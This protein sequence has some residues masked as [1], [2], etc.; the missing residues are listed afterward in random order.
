MMSACLSAGISVAQ[1]QTENDGADTEFQ[2][3]EIVVTATRRE[4]RLVDISQSITALT[5]SELSDLG[6]DSLSSFAGLVPSL[7][8]TERG[9]GRTSITI[10]GVS[11]DPGTSSVSPVGI[12]IDDI[13]I[14]N[15]D[16]NSQADVR[17][18][19]LQRVEVLR[20]PQ[21]TLYGEG[22][23]GGV[24][25]YITNKA[26]PSDFASAVDMSYGSISGGDNSTA[27]DAMVNLPII[28]DKLALRIVGTYRDLGGYIDNPLIGVENFN[29]SEINALR[30]SLLW[31]LTDNATVTLGG[32]LSDIEVAGDNITRGGSRTEFIAPSLNPRQDD[33]DLIH[34]TFEYGFPAF[35]FTSVSGFHT[36]DSA[37]TFVDSDLG[38]QGFVQPAVSAISDVI[39]ESSV[40][41]LGQDNENF[42]QELRLVSN[43]EGPLLWTLGAWY[44]DGDFTNTGSRIVG[45][46]P[47]YG[48]T[49]DLFFL[50]VP[51][52]LGPN[53][54]GGP[55]G[56]AIPGNLMNFPSTSGYENTAIFGEVSYQLTD[57]LNVQLGARYFEE[58]RSTKTPLE[59]GGFF[60]L[61][62]LLNDLQGIPNV[63][64]DE[65][66]T[67]N[68]VTPKA[69]I[70][71][72]ASENANVYFTFATG[73]RSGGRNG[74][75]GTP[76]LGFDC[77][78]NYKEDETQNYE[79]GTKFVSGNQRF[80]VF[81][82]V[83]YNDWKDMQ[84]L[85]FDATTFASCVNNAGS[86]H[87][88]GAEV[89]VAAMLTEGLTLRLGA[90]LIEAELD[91]DLPGADG[92]GAIIAK[93]TKLP[94]VPEYKFGGSLVYNW[95]WFG[96]WQGMGSL[97]VSN[98]GKS[99]AALEPG[100]RGDLIQPA[101]TI[102]NARIGVS[103][104]TVG[105]F[106]YVN[107]L[108]DEYAVYADD[109]FGG[110]HRNQPRTTGLN[111]RFKF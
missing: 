63:A 59:T 111:L 92:P 5:G 26:D 13:A 24:V 68:A 95:D 66:F 27:I 45:P 54:L 55:L 110:I 84:V 58:T 67:I 31:N 73:V 51:A 81:G 33:Y 23:M 64:T 83:F 77:P 21:G 19:D 1:A 9:P 90:T 30:F 69:T 28:E 18:F 37:N 4:E 82:S 39:V 89:E 32:V 15:D 3:E 96:D 85:I 100:V 62:Q 101:Y 71:Y 86:A 97:D 44:R 57:K 105:V 80:S 17:S 91:V 106:L 38:I 74:G 34:L 10:R 46:V 47:T 42:T 99:R 52:S 88:S 70:S 12:Y 107:N 102:S 103:N 16:Q 49:G 20:G 61:T 29:S 43:A 53:P 35:D 50:G 75:D 36:R 104:E 25:R 76:I 79:L 109:T 72:D 108:T 41:S 11:A 40:V 7:N 93:G 98:V 56:E 48:G 65:S 22:A 87:T 8:F 78:T 14:T 94:N 6:M 60:A 2:I